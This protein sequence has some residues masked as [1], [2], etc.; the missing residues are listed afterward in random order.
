M[1]CW[2]RIDDQSWPYAPLRV[3]DGFESLKP[4]DKPWP[5]VTVITPSLNQARY[6][7]ESL[8]SVLNQNYPDLEYI[9]VDGNSTDG[10]QESPSAL[11]AAAHPPDR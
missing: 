2:P 9:V 1:I 11:R 7:E 5:R 6:V 8:L 10:S 4:A 3:V